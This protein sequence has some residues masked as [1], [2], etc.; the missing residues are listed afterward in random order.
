M[1]LWGTTGSKPDHKIEAYTVGN[2]PDHDDVLVPYDCIASKAHA[3]MLHAIG[4]LDAQ[5]LEDLKRILDE[6]LALHQKG[7]FVIR[8]EDEDCHTAIESYL[9]HELGP[10]GEKIHTARSRNDQILTALR[11]YEKAELIKIGRLLEGWSR[12]LNTISDRDGNIG[13]PGFTHTRKAM[14]TT[15]GT[16]LGSFESACRDNLLLLDAVYRLIDQSPLGTAA[17]FGVPVINLKRDMTSSAL[18]FEKVMHNPMYA[19]LSRGKFES[20]LLHLCTQIMFDLNRFACDLILFSLP[21]F[22]FFVLPEAFCTGSSIMAQ[23]K[24]PDVL[25]IMRAKYHLVL[26]HELTIKSLIGNLISGYHRDVQLTKGPLFETIAIVKDSLEMAAWVLEGLWIDKQACEKA[27]S[28]ELYTTEKVYHWVQQGMPFR[29][30]YR[31]A[32]KE[33]ETSRKS[34]PTPKRSAR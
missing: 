8:P 26:G 32:A 14:P 29:S 34:H 31:K 30:A 33:L 27:L 15:I 16:W 23:K 12:C 19:Q 7:R 18:G 11:L 1:T 25:E 4:I 13:F 20:S 2:D 24:N 17:G 9:T 5:E 22:G 6:I 3:E 21:D 28:D 10:A